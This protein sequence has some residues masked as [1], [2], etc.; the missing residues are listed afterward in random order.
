MSMNEVPKEQN[1]ARERKGLRWSL[2]ALSR[3]ILA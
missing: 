1:I 2:G 3:S